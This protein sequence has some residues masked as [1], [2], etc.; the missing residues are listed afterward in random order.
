MCGKHHFYDDRISARY[1]HEH[2]QMAG[3]PGKADAIPF[4]ALEPL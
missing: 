4:E 3:A 2:D 1:T